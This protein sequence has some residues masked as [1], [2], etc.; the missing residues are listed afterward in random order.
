MVFQNKLLNEFE[1]IIMRRDE[2]EGKKDP[3]GTLRLQLLQHEYH[4]KNL[5]KTN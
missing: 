5:N 3:G 2:R 1:R 4:H